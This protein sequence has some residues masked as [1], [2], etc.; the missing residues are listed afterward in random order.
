MRAVKSG[1][2]THKT[3]PAK[4]GE[5][6]AISLRRRRIVK[7]VMSVGT[8]L[9][10]CIMVVGAIYLWR[11]GTIS[12]WIGS[13]EGKVEETLVDAGLVVEVVN[14]YGGQVVTE[15]ELKEV[16]NITIG[17]ALL[18]QNINAIIERIESHKWIN[19]AAVR[20]DFS[21]AIVINVIEHQPAALWQVDNKLW[22][23]SDEG[24]QIDDDNLE[25]FNHLPMIS[26]V[27]AEKELEKLLIATSSN[28]ELFDQV[29]TASWVGGRRWDIFLKNGIKIM[30]PELELADAW[31]K[32]ARFD[33]EQHL[34]AR[35]I[36]AVDFRIK[37]KTVVRLTP[38]EAA[39]RRLL[40]KT[41]GEG[42]KI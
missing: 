14:I 17:A 4:R 31:Q 24:I 25:Y 6:E 40:A 37:D 34:L 32:L 26:G 12:G 35:N 42:E 3:T 20:R 29:E 41:S 2:H 10:M 18:S 16:A 1:Y 36:L 28:A 30:L 7:S 9:G 39:R 23:V 27:G 15:E 21:G 22:V 8:T 5:K 38:E 33:E 11:S 13:V 19:K